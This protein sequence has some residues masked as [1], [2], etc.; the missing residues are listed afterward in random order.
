MKEKFNQ[1]MEKCKQNKKKTALSLFAIFF[2]FIAL[3]FG[4]Y[5]LTTV[6]EPSQKIVE[7][8]KKQNGKIEQKKTVG[9]AKKSKVTTKETDEKKAKEEKTAEKKE[10][11]KQ[12]EEK[13]KTSEKKASEPSKPSAPASQS[14]ASK[15]STPAPEQKPAPQQPVAP[16]KPEHTHNFQ[17]VYVQQWVVDQPAWTETV[18]TPVY[19]NQTVWI[20]N[21]CGAD[22]TGNIDGHTKD[23]MMSGKPECGSYHSEVKQIQTGTN[24]QTIQHPEVGH[25]ENVISYYQCS[26]GT[27][28]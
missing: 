15:P 26:C 28:K 19:E 20:C 23:A 22:I 21:G 6:N 24:T 13:E 4:I 8:E 5:S 2:L 11:A 17:P 16:S 25:N 18:E 9:E 12:S 3:G 10:E 14:A 27:T 7:K 1:F